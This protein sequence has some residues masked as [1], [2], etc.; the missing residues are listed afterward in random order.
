MTLCLLDL[1]D[2]TNEHITM[3]VRSPD[4]NRNINE[5]FYLLIEISQILLSL[6]L[7]RKN[8]HL[9]NV[10]GICDANLN[11]LHYGKMAKLITRCYYLGKFGIKSFVWDGNYSRRMAIGDSGYPLLPWLL[12]P[13]ITPITTQWTMQ[14][15]D[16]MSHIFR[17]RNVIVRAFDVSRFNSLIF[18]RKVCDLSVAGVVLHNMCISNRINP[19]RILNIEFMDSYIE[20]GGGGKIKWEERKRFHQIFKFI[21]KKMN[22]RY[23]EVVYSGK[24]TVRLL[25]NRLVVVGYTEKNWRVFYGSLIFKTL[26]CMENNQFAFTFLIN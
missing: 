11:S 9:I 18:P 17:T 15:D 19:F 13:V 4:L 24:C 16:S 25:L 3:P 23:W 14:R 10:Q 8:Y 6:Y 21:W 2:L 5:L 1:L 20:K 22:L 26:H 7:N 12:T